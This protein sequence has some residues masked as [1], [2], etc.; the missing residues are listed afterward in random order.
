MES[1]PKNGEC[2]EDCECQCYGK[3]CLCGHRKHYGYC[4]TNCCV[5]IKCRN[6]KYCF[7]QWRKCQ[8]YGNEMCINCTIQMGKHILTNE[9]DNCCV[10]LEDKIMLIL[11][12]KH[13]VC[14]DCWYKITIKGFSDDTDDDDE[15]KPLCPLCRNFNDWL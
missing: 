11:K 12:C 7:I 13:K 4:P 8:S 1:C 6:F 15:Y 9:I 10:C 14:N 5:P 2:L 3:I